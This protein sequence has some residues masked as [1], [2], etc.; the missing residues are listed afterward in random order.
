MSDLSKR[1][2]E[3]LRQVASEV[4]NNGVS[5]TGETP[6]QIAIRRFKEAFAAEDAA[7]A[8]AAETPADEPAAEDAPAEEAD[9]DG[10]D[11]D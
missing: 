4:E 7:K 6:E 10:G 1:V 8:A 11:S 2:A 9:A 3:A 5:D